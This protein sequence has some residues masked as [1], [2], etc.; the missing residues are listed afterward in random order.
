MRFL[1]DTLVVDPTT[2][3]TMQVLGAGLPR[4]AT[5]SMQAAMESEQINC[6]PSMHM[7][8][9]APNIARSNLVLQAMQ[10]PN[11]ERRQKLLYELFD[12][13][14]AT[15]DFPGCAVID[16]LMDMYPD[17]KIVL[18]LRPGGGPSWVKSIK[19][20]HWAKDTSY[21]VLTFL[22]KTDRNLHAMW[23]IYVQMC[24]RKFGLAEDE[25]FTTKHYDA[26]NAWVH[27][28]AT[29]RGR[30][31]LEHEPKDGW[32]PICQFL[33]K[34]TPENEPYPHRNDAAEVRMIKRILYARGIVS[35]LVLIGTTYGAARWFDLL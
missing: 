9:I 27:A 34:E 3:P 15:S 24:M 13:F 32:E 16:D 23:L 1:S 7:A 11:T 22:W 6:H 25:V 28:E 10:E 26:H 29:R 18:N 8:H 12:G 5:S 20:L 31:V 21:Y 33:G 4:C 2:K 30:E 35:W 19:A 14:Q 17:A